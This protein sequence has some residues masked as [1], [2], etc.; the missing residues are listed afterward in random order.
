MAISP[1]T[2][3]IINGIG[4]VLEIYPPSRLTVMSPSYTPP[5]IDIR[6]LQSDMEKIGRDF[7]QAIESATSGQKDKK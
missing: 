7:H 1:R 4:S 3:N 2:K 6:N 5:D